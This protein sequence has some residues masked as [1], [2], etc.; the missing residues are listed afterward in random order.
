MTGSERQARDGRSDPP[1][2]SGAG[3]NATEREAAPLAVSVAL[4]TYNGA[5]YLDRQLE[6]IL[7]QTVLPAELVVGDDRS[8]DN[9]T[10]RLA[11]FAARAPFPVRV[12]VNER[13][14]GVTQ[15]FAACVARCRGDVVVLT[16]QD[17]LWAPDRVAR[18]RDAF[19]R[20]PGLSYTYSD[21]PLIDGDDALVG[22]MIF[23]SVPILPVDRARLAHGDDLL[24]VILRYGVLYGATMA[25]RREQALAVLPVP[26]HWSHDEWWSLALSAIGRSCRLDP[27][28]QYR[29]HAAQVVGAGNARLSTTLQSARNRTLGHYEADAVRQRAGIAAARANDALCDTLAPLLEAKL[30][31]IEDRRYLHRAGLAA[32]PR[33]ARQLAR[34][35]YTRFAGGTRSILKDAALMATAWRRRD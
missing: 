16:D 12:H 24:P 26:A 6:T 8:S 27:V 29:Q 9:T 28:T 7:H 23:D 13:Q 19:A 33:F 20:D 35:G 11:A 21:A 1:P 14:L 32:L 4:C 17:D 10:A 18:T 22:R 5:R 25:V 31:F 34:G 2:D 30:H 3:Q 15:N